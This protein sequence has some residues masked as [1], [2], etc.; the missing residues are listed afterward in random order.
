MGVKTGYNAGFVIDR[1]TRDR[2]VAENPNSAEIIKPWLRG[3]DVRRWQVEYSDQYIIF[4]YRDVDIDSY[5][6]VKDYLEP[7]RERLEQRA[8]SHLHPWYE[9]QQ[10]QTGIYENFEKP[11]IIY[12]DIAKRCEFAFDDQGYFGG[13]TIYFIPVDDLAL[14]GILNSSVVEFFYGHISAMIQ[15]DYLR[16]FT[17]YL[18]QVPIPKPTKPQREAIEALVRKLLDAEGQGPQ[19]EC[20]ERELNAL[21]YEVYGL[22]EDEI[23]IIEQRVQS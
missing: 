8:T 11:K 2:L 14:L 23:Y 9:L 3:R 20:W 18:E 21:V 4:T 5:P 15:Q 17:Q 16:F 22:T 10:P 6:A 1:V 13:N 7:M 12:P 19:V